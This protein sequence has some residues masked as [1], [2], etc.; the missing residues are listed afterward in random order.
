MLST[1]HGLKLSNFSNQFSSQCGIRGR[2]ACDFPFQ[3]KWIAGRNA[4]REFRCRACIAD[5]FFD[6]FEA[7]EFEASA[8]AG[9]F[10]GPPDGDVADDLLVKM[11]AQRAEGP[12]R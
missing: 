3:N 8:A 11:K 9:F 2:P 7:S 4:T 5:F 10:G 12:Q 6:A 1:E